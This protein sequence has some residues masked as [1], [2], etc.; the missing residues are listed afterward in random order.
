[1]L[2][3]FLF[4]VFQN[5]IGQMTHFFFLKKIINDSMSADLNYSD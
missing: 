4:I 1:M 5:I 3:F 2:G